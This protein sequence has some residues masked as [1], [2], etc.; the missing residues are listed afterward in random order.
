MTS[1]QK[2]T[3]ATQ[4]VTTPGCPV[5]LTQT[6]GCFY[7]DNSYSNRKTWDQAEAIFQGFESHVHLATIDTQDV[8]TQVRSSGLGL[9]QHKSWI[10]SWF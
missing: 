6:G 7:L 8:C 4:D 1:D 10:G 5:E 2:S 9:I 3:T